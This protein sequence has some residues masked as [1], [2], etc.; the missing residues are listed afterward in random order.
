[1]RMLVRNIRANCAALACGVTPGTQDGVKFNTTTHASFEMQCRGATRNLSPPTR[2]HPHL[3]NP[4]NYCS[5]D[6]THHP[7]NPPRLWC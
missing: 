2:P 7:T 4:L 5:R 1:M 3:D 6:P